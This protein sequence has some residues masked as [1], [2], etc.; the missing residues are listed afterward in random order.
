MK[1]NIVCSLL[2]LAALVSSCSEKDYYDPTFMQNQARE[3]FPVDYKTIDANHTWE[4]VALVKADIT[5]GAEAP[6]SL[7]VYAGNPFASVGDCALLGKYAVQAGLNQLSIDKP[8]VAKYLYL[9]TRDSQGRAA[10]VA[11]S[12]TED[13]RLVH[14]F[15]A[16]VSKR[17]L[18]TR[19]ASRAP[20]V[21]YGW[22]PATVTAS[23]A[24]LFPADAP[25][26]QE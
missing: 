13:G 7:W 5:F 20:R 16:S 8:A 12:V 15:T 25:V 2:G 18:Q 23:D 10:A 14:D 3:A 9:L 6:D 26:T 1:I 22:T 4:T 11:D 19:A 21:D 17:S 24:S